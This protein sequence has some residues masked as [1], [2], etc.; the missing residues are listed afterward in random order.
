ME[1]R[2]CVDKG[3]E[4][5]HLPA[6]RGAHNDVKPGDMGVVHSQHQVQL[7][8]HVKDVVIHVSDEGIA[9]YWSQPHLYNV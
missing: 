7:A 5:W 4:S 9:Q 3:N 6:W 2:T 1:V 8:V